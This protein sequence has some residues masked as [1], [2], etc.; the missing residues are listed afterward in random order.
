[1][2]KSE[3]HTHTLTAANTYGVFR[4]G[5]EERLFTLE[6]YVKEKEKVSP[7]QWNSLFTLYVYRH[8]E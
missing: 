5:E 7:I 3:L 6:K 2:S 8:I 4:E 1:M